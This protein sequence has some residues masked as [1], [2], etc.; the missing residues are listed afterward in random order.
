MKILEDLF[1]DSLAEVYY[2]E[3]QLIKAFPKMAKAN[4][5]EAANEGL[6]EMSDRD[7]ES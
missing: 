5:N 6:L 2:A 7:R 4:C 1:L 3:N